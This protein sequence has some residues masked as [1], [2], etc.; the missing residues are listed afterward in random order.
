MTLIL[1]KDENLYL[2]EM[3]QIPVGESITFD[4]TFKV[5]SY[6]GFLREDGVWVPQYDSLFIVLSQAGRVLTWQLTK[7]TGFTQIGP[8][9]SDLKDRGSNLK[10]YIDDC[11]RLRTKNT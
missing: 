4:H 10:V 8:L 1:A 11:C 3:T 6:I 2:A 5:A 7:G 9:L